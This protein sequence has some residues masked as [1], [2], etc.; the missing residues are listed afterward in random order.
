MGERLDKLEHTYI[1]THTPEHHSAI[2]RNEVVIY[3]HE[4]Q[5]HP[6]K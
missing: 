5:K 6:A 4:S 1:H 3:I 2:N